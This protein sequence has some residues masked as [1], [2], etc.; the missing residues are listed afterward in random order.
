ML[1][2]LTGGLYLYVF[3]FDGLETI[4][5][6]RLMPMIE[7]KYG[8]EAKVGK[9]HGGL[10]EGFTLEDISINYQDSIHRYEMIHIP[11]LT[12]S[13]AF[14]DIWNMNFVLDYLTLDSVSIHLEQDSSGHWLLPK[15]PDIPSS[16][17]SGGAAA[18]PIAVQNFNIKHGDVTLLRAHDTLN[19]DDIIIA[20]AFRAE[21]GTIS[22]DVD[23]CEFTSNQKRLSLSSAGGKVT[24]AQKRLVFRD[25][26]LISLNTRVKLDGSIAF[27]DQPTGTVDFS[28]DHLDLADVT[29]YVGPKLTGVLDVNGNLNFVGTKLQGSVD[30]GGTFLFMG[31]QNLYVDFRYA[32]EVIQVDTVIGTIFG[33]CSV[34]GSGKVDLSGKPEV[35]SL[36]ADIRQ[37][38][39]NHLL[40]G[41][42]ESNLNGHIVL[43]GR[44]FRSKDLRLYTDVDLYESSFD[45]YPIQAANGRMLIT[46]DSISFLDSFKVDYFENTFLASGRVTY[47]GDM[48]LK[49]ALQLNNLDRW[50]GKLFIDQPG[51]RGYAEATLSGPTNDPDLNGF[52][53]SDSVWIYGLYSDS[54]YATVD[55]KRFLTGKTGE[56]HADFF[57]GTA[58]GTEYD[59]GHA[60]LH[61]DSNLVDIDTASITNQYVHL[62]GGGRLDYASIPM[63]LTLDTLSLDLFDQSFYNQ[64]AIDLTIDSLGFDFKKATI[65]GDGARLSVNGRTNYDESMDLL[66][67]LYNVKVGPWQNLFLD[68]V[69]AEG[70]LSCEGSLKGSFMQP[71]FTVNASVDSLEYG[72]LYLGRLQTFMRYN[73]SLLSIDSLVVHSGPGVYKA[74]GYM[75]ADLAL[76]T[77]SIERFPNLPMQIKITASDQRFDLVELFLPSIQ[78]L[79][80]D[81]LADFT[82]SGTPQNPHLEGEAYIKGMDL[83]YVDLEN[84]IQADSAGISMRDNQIVIDK[85]SAYV[86]D[87]SKKKKQEQKKYAYIS[88][89]I[90]VKS[91][92][93][94]SY[95]L[96]VTVPVEMPFTYALEDA[97]GFF[98][99]EF[100][101]RGDSPPT[102]TGDVH[103]KSLD[104]RS[105]FAEP[106]AGSPIMAALAGEN[107]WNLNIDVDIPSN[108]KIQ[109]D[110]INAEFSGNM[111]VTRQSGNY[112]FV[113]ELDIVRGNGYLF[114][115]VFTLDA[116]GTAIFSGGDSLNP[117]LDITAYTYYTELV[118]SAAEE[119]A[120]KT[121]RLRV[122]IHITG[123]LDVPVIATT[124]DS[125]VGSVADVLP[126]LI[127]NSYSTDSTQATGG[128]QNRLAG[129]LST[130]VSQVGSRQLGDL[131][132]RLSNSLNRQIGLPIIP[133]L[134]TLEIT[135]GY[136]NGAYDPLQSQLTVGFS[137][138]GNVYAYYSSGVNTQGGSQAG[139]EIRLSKLIL[140][141]GLKDE[142]QLYHLNLKLHTEW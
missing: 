7:R 80:G 15:P 123:T 76:T 103:L 93:L 111:N 51:G 39:L 29:Q 112:S 12:T 41:T 21:L 113:G 120:P 2:V 121:E 43:N 105:N 129:Y 25:V 3:K 18:P 114:G 122:G 140:L 26:S 125:D 63:Q 117:T 53:R 32:D 118:R 78:Q 91:L 62:Q 60:S 6:K 59:F 37:F 65:A 87:K 23:Q 90:T 28:V 84:H 73:D 66:F 116:G 56:V 119:S 131:S 142:E 77:D 85:I 71:E 98:R 107:T 27:V 54:A 14:P 104:Y 69:I 126:L 97:R 44:S 127:A 72:S 57:H 8:V 10:W 50:K 134:Q 52:F 92:S 45:D 136:T 110:D 67:S 108:F 48:D 9:I 74:H 13:L 109:N 99:G 33:D 70:D 139:V 88:G 16:A 1:I 20:L 47:S 137:T 40:E 34:D 82:I 17:Q 75:H 5:N 58:W 102:V 138:L 128:F 61:I 30:L 55:I 132:R 94:L 101:V 19:F 106:G 141:E 135:P 42:F 68:S 133:E 130:Q 22:V 100:Y 95:D 24:Y 79:T 83:T 31:L 81:M 89:S 64:S 38:N 11:R 86:I 96:T 46:T 35:Y 115:K 4:V 49:L 36:E 124:E